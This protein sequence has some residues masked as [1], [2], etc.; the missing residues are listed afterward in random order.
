MQLK[1]YRSQQRDRV[2]S[3]SSKIERQSTTI[4]SETRVPTLYSLISDNDQKQMFEFRRRQVC[5]RTD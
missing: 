4:H 1:R 3:S 2:A 5:F